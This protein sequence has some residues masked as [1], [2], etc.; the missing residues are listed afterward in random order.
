MQISV[1]IVDDNTIMRKGIRSVL[2]RESS[3][4]VAGEVRSGTDAIKWIEESAVDV[5]LMDIRMPGID[6]IQATT[7]IANVRPETR[8]LALTNLESPTIVA[9]AIRAG[10]R[11]FMKYG[12]FT[13][14]ELVSAIHELAAGKTII[15]SS[16]VTMPAKSIHKKNELKRLSKINLRHTLSVNL[17]HRENQ[18]LN[19]IAEG[20]A[21]SD[22]AK[23]LSIEEKTVKNHINNIYSKLN[24]KNR[25][26]AIS[27]KLEPSY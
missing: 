17:T 8:I 19:L 4:K 23:D 22:I 3:I 13:P 15:K 20:K 11:G 18:V 27:F 12:R 5:V 7:E 1:L 10:A 9:Q 25:Y 6:G 14:G 2:E 16:S 26:E 24:I 21:N